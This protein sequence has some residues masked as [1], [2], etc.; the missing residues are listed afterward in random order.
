MYLA[1]PTRIWKAGGSDRMIEFARSKGFAPVH[2]FSCGDF[3]D[4]EGGIVGREG[5][6]QWTLHLQRGCHWSGYFGISD[7]VMRELQDRLRW[8]EE[9]RIRVFYEDDAGVPFDP[10]WEA[11]Y[12]VLKKKYGDL[13]AKL[14]GPHRMIALVGPSAVGKTYWIE[15]LIR[16]HGERPWDPLFRKLRWIPFLKSLSD[17]RLMRV[18][19]TTTRPPRDERD[20]HYYNRV[21]EKQFLEGVENRE[22]LEHDSYLGNY[23]GS[24]LSE[25]KGVLRENDGI[26]AI[27]PKGALELYKCRHEINVSIVLLRPANEEVLLKNFKRRGEKDMAKLAESIRRAKEFVLPVHVNHQVLE[28]TGTRDDEERVLGLMG[29][30]LK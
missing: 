5:T 22:F 2:P 3:C 15:R 6:L 19:N 8:D 26:F 29:S 12:D 20:G 11:Q 25:I 13:L 28:L 4:F 17:G 16:A 27:T 24:S 1:H 14:R 9:K 30:L 7:G 23:Y 21:S 18:K 10:E